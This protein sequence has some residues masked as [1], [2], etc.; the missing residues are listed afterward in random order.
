MAAFL[1]VQG[2]ASDAARWR[3]RARI[4]RAGE[5]LNRVVAVTNGATVEVDEVRPV[6]DFQVQFV[7]ER[8][9]ITL[10]PA[11]V[12][13]Q[14]GEELGSALRLHDV[15]VQPIVDKS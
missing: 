15:P 2:A 10:R 1:T 9:R 6:G 5:P 14:R 3:T 4:V 12:H 11:V 8:N 13:T 7:F